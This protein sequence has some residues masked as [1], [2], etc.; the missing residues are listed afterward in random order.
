MLCLTRTGQTHPSFRS[1]VPHW[2]Y[3]RR[4]WSHI[5]V[6]VIRLGLVIKALNIIEEELRAWLYFC[7]Q[8]RKDN[9]F[10]RTELGMSK[11]VSRAGHHVDVADAAGL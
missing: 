8:G 6:G 7:A 3:R 9:L 4:T 1:S 11:F 2:P 10:E 5:S